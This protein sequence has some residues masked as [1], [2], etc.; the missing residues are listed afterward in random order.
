MALLWNK[1]TKR[2]DGKAGFFGTLAKMCLSEMRASLLAEIDRARTARSAA[3]VPQNVAEVAAE[4][5][6][7]FDGAHRL[8]PL[9]LGDLDGDTEAEEVD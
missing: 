7:V 4:E 5:A 6:A 2:E 8:P 3:A 1:V 9:D